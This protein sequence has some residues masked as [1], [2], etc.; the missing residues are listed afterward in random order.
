MLAK[1]A[2]SLRKRRL[3]GL[4]RLG[5]AASSGV[6]LALAALYP[7]WFALAWF[8]FVPLLIALRGLTAKAAYGIGL[9]AGLALF[10]LSTHWM[11][12]FLNLLKG[13]G[14]LHAAALAALYWFYCAQLVAIVAWLTVLLGRR[15]PTLWV[16]PLVLTAAFAGFPTLFSVQIG[17]TQ[18]LF[19]AALQ[20][21][22]IA[23]VY[24][25]DLVIGLVN[26]LL[27]QAMVGLSGKH[28]VATRSALATPLAY[29]AVVGW[30]TYGV[31]SLGYWD[32][33]IQ[34]WD[35]VAVGI[36]QPH[37]P[38]STDEP[39]PRP[40]FTRAYSVPMALSDRLAEQ[41][42]AVI[43]WPELRMQHYFGLPHVE[44]AFRH[45]VRQW[46]IPLV[47][48]DLESKRR[49]G[50]TVNRNASLFIDAHGEMAGRYDKIK[51][52]PFAEYLP[53]FGEWPTAKAFIRNWLG[54]FYGDI[55]AG[56]G[57]AVFEL[58][59]FSLVPLICYEVMFPRFAA[60]AVPN[61]AASPILLGQSN[62][63]WF[64]E[65]QQPYQHLHA[66][67]LRSVENRAPLIHVTNNG[68]SAVVLPSGRI[69][70]RSDYHRTAAYTVSVPIDA[71]AGNSFYS[72]HPALLISAL[73]GLLALMLLWCSMP[74]RWRN[75]VAR[76]HRTRQ[77]T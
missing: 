47:F 58:D 27:A 18:S 74:A 72:R 42:V 22:A 4:W 59:G 60:K 73:Y 3:H 23:G 41:S 20:G 57:P 45:Q 69:Q 48:Q 77:G 35:T 50:T 36:V 70:F 25:L 54:E 11:M 5:L 30:F 61:D 9:V 7:P 63:S 55:S 52:V 44:T 65:T 56:S 75:A 32:R 17:E 14:P 8:A 21:T 64:G 15:F 10:A 68:P 12:D 19:P 6:L 62:N 46:Q 2:N 13:Y 43:V 24:G 26:A 51:R 28:S 34:R 49:D 71:A 1:D 33:E 38:P 39:E 16:F 31:V 53:W 29:L 37:E 67:V 40:G 66:S 76:A